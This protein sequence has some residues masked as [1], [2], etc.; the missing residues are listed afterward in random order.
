LIR[1][2]EISHDDYFNKV[3]SY[4]DILS[5]ELRGEILKVY[6]TSESMFDNMYKLKP[7]PISKLLQSNHTKTYI[8][9]SVV[10]MTIDEESQVAQLELL[11]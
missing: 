1:F 8:C 6:L 2:Y 3:K 5:K 10:L 9:I 7:H 11:K 4:E